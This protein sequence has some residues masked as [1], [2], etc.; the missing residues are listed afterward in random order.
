MVRS[1]AEM[2]EYDLFDV[3][4]QAGYHAQPRTRGDRAAAFVNGQAGWLQTLPPQAAATLRA[5]ATQFGLGGT[6][7]L[8]STQLFQTPEVAQAGGVAALKQAGKP[9]EVVREA[10][11]RLFAA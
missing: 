3:L 5:I 4:A 1:L 10:K 9:P 6:E 11:D 8:E 2:E 7:A